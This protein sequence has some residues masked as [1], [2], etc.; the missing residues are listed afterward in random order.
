M[1]VLQG[2]SGM[3]RWIQKDHE[4]WKST[5]PACLHCRLWGGSV[6][7]PCSSK[8]APDLEET[9]G[10][11]LAVTVLRY[12]PANDYMV[13]VKFLILQVVGLNYKKKDYTYLIYISIS[14]KLDHVSNTNL[15]SLS[16]NCEA[17]FLKS[18]FF[19]IWTVT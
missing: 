19:A 18:Q 10:Y 2:L 14:L 7:G 3:P 6:S 15:W 17:T 1:L 4:I 16:V 5:D 9:F 13:L 8:K 11:L 12:F